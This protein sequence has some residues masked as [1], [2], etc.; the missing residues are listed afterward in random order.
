MAAIL[1]VILCLLLIGGDQFIK[2]LVVE[3]LK[4][5]EY[6]DVIDGFLRFRYV[7]NTGAV[8]GS[9]ATHTV[10][11]TI[12]SN[13]SFLTQSDAERDQN[14]PLLDNLD[15]PLL[16]NTPSA[17]L[18]PSLAKTYIPNHAKVRQQIIRSP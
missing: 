3:Y 4:P 13:V 7:E 17:F 11:L 12:F 9:F 15:P 5:I 16:N 2:H 14:Y 1:S 10:F 18:N 6:I 8:F